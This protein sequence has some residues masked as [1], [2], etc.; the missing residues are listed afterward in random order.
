MGVERDEN[1]ENE[2]MQEM[3]DTADAMELDVD[4][5]DL[6][7]VQDDATLKEIYENQK[8]LTIEAQWFMEK[9]DWM[10]VLKNVK[11]F[12]VLKMP[13][14]IQA[15]FFLNKFERYDICEPNSNKMSWKKAKELFTEE[16][17]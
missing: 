3:T 10:E 1:A 8:T 6:Q 5:F 17:P 13:H 14:I 16:L 11:A 4:Y 9:E 2:L 12:R 15:L 7:I